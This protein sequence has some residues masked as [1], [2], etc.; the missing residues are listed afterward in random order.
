M[1]KWGNYTLVELKMGSIIKVKRGDKLEI[2][3][4]NYIIG[5]KEGIKQ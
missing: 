2:K 1:Q 3:K 4:V 5:E